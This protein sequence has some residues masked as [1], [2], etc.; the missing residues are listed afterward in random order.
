MAYVVVVFAMINVLALGAA[1]Y[2]LWRLR[3]DLTQTLEESI[4]R[5]VKR[6]EDRVEKRLERAQRP[7][8]DSE[9]THDD[10]VS[11]RLTPGQPY[12]R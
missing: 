2:I 12:R 9:E 10:G 4:Q 1:G 5:E 7:A 11:P 6:L 8:S 3:W